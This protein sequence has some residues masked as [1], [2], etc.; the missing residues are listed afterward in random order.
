MLKIYAHR[1]DSANFTENTRA[2]F[3]AALV[4]GAYGIETDLR[5]TRDGKIVLNH[6]NNLSRLAKDPTLLSELELPELKWRLSRW[7]IS[8]ITLN[9]FWC[10][11]AGKINLNLEVKEIEV[12]EPLVQ[13]LKAR[14]CKDILITSSHWR[15][16]AAVKE[17]LAGVQIGPVVE[18]FLEAKALIA[19]DE[20]FDVISMDRSIYDP[21]MVE[22]CRKHRRE[23]LLWTV[24]DP[25]DAIALYNQ[26]VGGIFTDDP[27]RLCNAL[28]EHLGEGR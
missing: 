16:L 19:G 14:D 26:G 9:S 2:A 24:N 28:S 18:D 20:P 11:F 23:L 22:L 13:F 25:D 12:F 6:D 1:G 10:A 7:G 15:H 5:L 21:S 4:A 3:K 17:K 27:G 8:L